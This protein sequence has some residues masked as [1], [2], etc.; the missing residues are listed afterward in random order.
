MTT[1]KHRTVAWLRSAACV[2][3][4]WAWQMMAWAVDAPLTAA[5]EARNHAELQRLLTVGVRPPGLPPNADLQAMYDHPLGRALANK[6]ARSAVLLIEAGAAGES[7][8]RFL[9]YLDRQ[10]AVLESMLRNGLDPNTVAH[11]A[12]LLHTS[13]AE[14]DLPS[15]ELLLA[16]GARADAASAQGDTA[17]HAATR[18][19]LKKRVLLV[20]RLLAAGATAGLRNGK[21]QTVLHLAAQ[22]ADGDLL[23]LLEFRGL[24][25]QQQ[26][27][28][29][30]SGFGYLY[31]TDAGLALQ[32]RYPLSRLTPAD[33][34]HAIQQTLRDDMDA[35][36]AALVSGASRPDATAWLARAIDH[37]SHACMALLLG[38]GADPRVSRRD[39]I[40]RFLELLYE[41]GD[42]ERLSARMLIAAGAR[43]GKRLTVAETEHLSDTLL[44]DP[45][46][47]RWLRAAGLTLATRLPPEFKEDEGSVRD[48]VRQAAGNGR[49]ALKPWQQALPTAYRQLGAPPAAGI[50]KRLTGVWRSDDEEAQWSFSPNGE[51]TGVLAAGFVEQR[52]RGTWKWVSGRIELSVAEPAPRQQLL[53]PLLWVGDELVVSS[54][55]TR[56]TLVRLSAT[57]VDLAG[58]PTTALPATDVCPRATQRAQAAQAQLKSLLA[59]DPS[60]AA[61]SAERRGF[62]A[63]AALDFSRFQQECLAGYGS[64]E[65][66]REFAQCMHDSEG[67]LALVACLGSAA[68]FAPAAKDGP[69]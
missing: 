69:R 29:G 64:N 1:D 6:D 63:L 12:P 68:A 23:T 47:V 43:F 14:A 55:L 35:A 21:G 33:R 20:E 38:M 59:G 56:Q 24:D 32:D 31:A 5:V 58:T 30:V 10:P 9:P 44:T 53:R 17:L 3:L 8:A 2:L 34:H 16:H 26:D 4:A 48:M 11:G 15:V 46:H 49:D 28:A 45:A 27:N 50:A 57:P 40:P 41:G 39:G 18:A 7:L 37:G 42:W 51:V 13:V 67:L 52:M 66:L 61:G 62:E 22:R 54:G 19:S 25:M 60:A 65:G 36:L